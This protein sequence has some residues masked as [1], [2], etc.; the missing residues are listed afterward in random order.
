[1]NPFN[2][3]IPFLTASIA[4]INFSANYVLILHPHN[5]NTIIFT[6]GNGLFP[7]R[8][9]V[10]TNVTG[11]M[12]SNQ[13]ELTPGKMNIPTVLKTSICETSKSTILDANTEITGR[14]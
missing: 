1:M 5:R 13:I 6:G 12:D 3:D 14:L 10:T 4:L 7:D 8:I 2:L 9:C 11:N